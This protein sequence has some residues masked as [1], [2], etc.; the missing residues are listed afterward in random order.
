VRVVIDTNRLQSEEL[1]GFLRMS[2]DNQAVLPDYVLM[3]IFK[4]GQP[5]EVRSAFSILAQFP[6]QVVA[7]KGT[8]SVCGLNP[9]HVAMPES[10]IN[11]EETSAFPE[12]LDHLKEA[13]RGGAV[14]AALIEPA[15]WAQQQ[16][17]RILSGFA[18][19]APAMEEF[20][21]PFT[22]TELR[23]IRQVKEEFT[24]AMTQKFFGLAAS[25]ANRI[26]ESLPNLVMPSMARR[27]DHYV[28][29]N[30]LGY[31]VY[32]M[33]RVR[34]GAKSWKGSIARNDSIDVMLAA[35]GTYFDGVMSADQLTNEVWVITRDLLKGTG[36]R[37]G[38]EYL[39]GYFR[40]V[41]SF[42]DSLH[43]PGPFGGAKY[44]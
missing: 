29:R 6:G 9:D 38:A 24:P 8:G 30:C 15:D 39:G 1:W 4:P 41:V 26:F 31:A 18:D 40:D 19:M 25:M 35:Y 23:I 12:F 5:D 21:A 44:P 34:A 37:T 16:M 36:T 27:P 3:E 2:P 42:L 17:D 7:L 14:D 33:S 32:M 13:G 28:F 22:P 43:G 10:M 11:E 20:L